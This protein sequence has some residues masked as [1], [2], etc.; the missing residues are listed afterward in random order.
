MGAHD[1]TDRKG[2]NSNGNKK[3]SKHRIQ[4]LYPVNR[5]AYVWHNG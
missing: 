5:R 3:A 2:N 4:W 1:D